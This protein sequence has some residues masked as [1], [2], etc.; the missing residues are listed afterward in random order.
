MRRVG[1]AVAC[2]LALAAAGCSSSSHHAQSAN[3]N[4]NARTS[5]AALTVKV[6]SSRPDMVTGESA[7]LQIDGGTGT[8]T[9]TA[10][11]TSL[12][13]TPVKKWWRVDGLPN[14]PSTINVQRGSLHASAA[15]TD[16]SVKGPVFSGPHMPLLACSTVAT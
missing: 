14:G 2:A 1:G 5:A 11:A 6:V 13:V 10:G 4:A 16:Y 8:P 9:A 12:T 7:L 15:V 3:A